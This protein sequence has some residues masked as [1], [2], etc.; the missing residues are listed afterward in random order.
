MDDI[1]N[2]GIRAKLDDSINRCKEKMGT[3]KITVSK[4]TK[5]ELE[6]IGVDNW[7]IW[8]KEPSV[9]DWSYSEPETCLILE[10]EAEVK[11]KNGEAASFK[12]GDLVVFPTGLD[13]TWT[14]KKKIRK[15][16]QFG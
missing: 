14:I 16:Y 7:G 9:F 10:G 3:K 12:T 6:K 15:R 11:G 2:E 4:P 13:C 1:I 5:E 8:E